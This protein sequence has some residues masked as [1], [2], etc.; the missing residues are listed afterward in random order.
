M[1]SGCPYVP[2]VSG[3][4]C[5]PKFVN[6]I[7]YILYDIIFGKFQQIYNLVHLETNMN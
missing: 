5:V 4:V 6:V 7:S 2:C 3:S 1:F